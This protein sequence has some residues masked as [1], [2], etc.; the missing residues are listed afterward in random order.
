MPCVLVSYSAILV[1]LEVNSTLFYLNFS[2]NTLK[3]KCGASS[4]EGLW[5]AKRREPVYVLDT[6]TCSSLPFYWIKDN[7]TSGMIPSQSWESFYWLYGEPS[8]GTLYG[9]AETCVS[10]IIDISQMNDGNC[11]ASVQCPVCQL[12]I[13]W[14]ITVTLAIDGNR[15]HS[16]G[17]FKLSHV[18]GSTCEGVSLS[19]AFELTVSCW[20]LKRQTF[21]DFLFKFSGGMTNDCIAGNET[22][23]L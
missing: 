17:S 20:T 11:W 16:V 19:A 6:A 5:T 10:I 8:C 7:T 23:S 2:A 22:V 9:A 18:A 13:D 1:Q 12:D 21:S 3:K 14:T 4:W 15:G